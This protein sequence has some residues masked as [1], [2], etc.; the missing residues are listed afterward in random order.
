MKELTLKDKDAIREASDGWDAVRIIRQEDDLRMGGARNLG[1][2]V[3][4]GRYVWFLDVDDRPYPSLLE[5]MVGIM[6]DT[7]AKVSVFNS[8]YS[9]DRELPER[10]YGVAF[11]GYDIRFRVRD[12]VLT[13]C[14][15]EP[16]GDGGG[17]SRFRG[18][19][20]RP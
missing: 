6:E 1:L 9:S 14:G 5:E 10:V 11:A 2:R 18:E 19:E 4:A 12:G 16:R 20:S 13:V 15:L 8:V 7:G 17:E 3:A